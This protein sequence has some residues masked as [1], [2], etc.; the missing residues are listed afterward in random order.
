MFKY[1]GG[2]LMERQ[3][4]KTEERRDKTWN[5]VPK[6]REVGRSR[7][8]GRILDLDREGGHHS[9]ERKEEEWVKI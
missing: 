6:R 2:D 7:H 9:T 3:M 1:Y 8:R 5:T 4:L